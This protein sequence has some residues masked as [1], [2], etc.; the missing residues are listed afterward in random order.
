MNANNQYL[1]TTQIQLV[2]ISIDISSI[3]LQLFLLAYYLLSFVAYL[4]LFTI[5]RPSGGV[6]D[7]GSSSSGQQ[8]VYVEPLKIKDVWTV[9]S[10][11]MSC[12]F[13]FILY[14]N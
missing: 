8:C 12:Q 9:V 14:F 5:P 6:P 3:Q 1:Y 10:F 7:V 13:K 2:F 4:V 11:I